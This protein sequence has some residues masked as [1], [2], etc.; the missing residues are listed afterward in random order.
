MSEGTFI[1]GK[2]ELE[3]LIEHADGGA[4][5]SFTCDDDARIGLTKIGLVALLRSACKNKG[6]SPEEVDEIVVDALKE[7][8][9]RCIELP[10]VD[11]YKH[12][13]D[14]EI[15]DAVAAACYTLLYYF[16][17]YAEAEQYFAQLFAEEEE[18]EELPEENQLQENNV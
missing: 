14:V 6:L 10:V 17:P 9:E 11:G 3:T 5:M 15:D 13:E 16:M 2:I 1:S 18:E 12:P 7:T 4:T 8:Y